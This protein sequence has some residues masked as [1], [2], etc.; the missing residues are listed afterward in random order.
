MTAS[1]LAVDAARCAVT[2]TAGPLRQQ[3]HVTKSLSPRR[4]LRNR[5]SATASLLLPPLVALNA[6]RA[7]GRAFR[8]IS[9]IAWRLHSDFGTSTTTIITAATPTKR[10][11]R[12]NTFRRRFDAP[13]VTA[14]IMSG[15]A[16]GNS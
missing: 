9:V 3:R 11:I 4:L 15:N 7:G 14:A 2:P 1:A 12:P 5:L 8:R 13:S 16:A 10:T 6:A